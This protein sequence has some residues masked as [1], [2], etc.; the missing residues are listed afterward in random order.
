MPHYQLIINRRCG[1]PQ[2]VINQTKW[3]L[4][5]HHA[6]AHIAN[7]AY[8]HTQWRVISLKE[9]AIFFVPLTGR[10]F[11]AFRGSTEDDGPE[12]VPE[13]SAAGFDLSG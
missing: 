6:H 10:R 13:G 11:L 2:M 12:A 5:Q 4:K 8:T 7:H 9:A 3:N 1:N